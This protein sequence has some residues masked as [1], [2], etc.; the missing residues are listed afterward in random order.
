MKIKRALITAF[1]VLF[2]FSTLSFCLIAFADDISYSY[3]ENTNTLLI[4]GSGDMEDYNENYMPPW[5]KYASECESVVISNGVTNI[6]SYAFSEFTKLT[7]VQIS[8]S[9][10]AVNF[11]SFSRCQS[12]CELYFPGSVTSIADPS[13]AYNDNV[14]K[15]NF[16]LK[17]DG[18][19]FALHYAKQN[20]IPFDMPS[21]ECGVTKATVAVKSMKAYYKYNAKVNGTF[22]IYSSGSQDTIGA[23]LDSSFNVLSSN[24]DISDSN[25]NFSITIDFQKGNTYYIRAGLVSSGLTGSFNLRIVPISYELAFTINAQKNR[26]GEPSDIL[27][28]DALVDGAPCSGIYNET[29][30]QASVTKTITYNNESRKIVFTPDSDMQVVFLTV[31]VNNDGYV[32]AKDYA[33]LKKNNSPYLPLFDNLITLE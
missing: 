16:V 20:S 26:A 13:F 15:D 7:T 10:K 1:V 30:T 22:R 25:T 32:N 21:T 12:L 23:V 33:I 2:I 29:V 17:S 19:A 3:D 27:I 28:T 4:S 8:D 18:G 11:G 5:H 31:D 9:V 14:L 6:G 24:D